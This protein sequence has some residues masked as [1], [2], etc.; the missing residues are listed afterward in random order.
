MPMSEETP[1][2][3]VPPSVYTENETKK[4]LRAPLQSEEK[5]KQAHAPFHV[6]FHP[7]RTLEE[8][9]HAL[10]PPYVTL[11]GLKKP[12]RKKTP[13]I[14][15]LN[16]RGPIC[17]KTIPSAGS[18]QCGGLGSPFPK[19]RCGRTAPFAA[20]T[21]TTS[22]APFSAASILNRPFSLFLPLPRAARTI[23]ASR[24]PEP[25]HPSARRR[26]SRLMQEPAGTA[27]L[28]V[29]VPPSRRRSL[30]PRRGATEPP[31]LLSLSLPT[32]F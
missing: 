9:G 29:P 12:G 5:G 11:P 24:P 20:S 13:F 16:K 18:S 21:K 26:A 31:K 28:P 2:L 32:S 8:H 17:L 1:S 6:P 10:S 15:T 7:G 19:P 3:K 23:G 4:N 22:T 30:P 27:A 25:P 14:L